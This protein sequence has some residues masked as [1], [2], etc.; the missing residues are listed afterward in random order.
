VWGPEALE[1][2]FFTFFAAMALA[3]L[4]TAGWSG[5]DGRRMARSRALVTWIAVPL[6]SGLILGVGGT[7]IAPGSPASERVAEAVSST[8]F[9]AVPLAVAALLGLV[10]GMSTR[11]RATTYDAAPGTAVSG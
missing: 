8:I 11:P 2:D 9:F 10:V 5:L 6:G 4:L 7:V 1:G 3:M